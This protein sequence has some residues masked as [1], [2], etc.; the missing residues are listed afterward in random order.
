MEFISNFQLSDQI[1]RYRLTIDAVSIYKY[2]LQA[3]LIGRDRIKDSLVPRIS[4]ALKAKI[5]INYKVIRKQLEC[6]TPAFDA[7]L[8]KVEVFCISFFAQLV[9]CFG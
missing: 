7:I 2:S 5:F 1:I 4:L 9:H 6:P 3:M 8:L